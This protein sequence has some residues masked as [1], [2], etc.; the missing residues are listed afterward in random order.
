VLSKKRTR[1]ASID[2]SDIDAIDKVASDHLRAWW[3]GQDDERG[4]GGLRR[5]EKERGGAS[6]CLFVR[7]K[8]G[9]WELGSAHVA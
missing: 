9:L 4:G 8:S 7:K 6:P 5:R 3:G 2:T 1:R